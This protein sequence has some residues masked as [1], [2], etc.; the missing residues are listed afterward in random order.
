MN[1]ILNDEVSS[2]RAAVIEMIDKKVYRDVKAYKLRDNTSVLEYN[3]QSFGLA[4][5]PIRYAPES[6]HEG[7]MMALSLDFDNINVVATFS[8]EEKEKPFDA[9]EWNVELLRLYLQRHQRVIYRPEC[10][11]KNSDRFICHIPMR[12][13]KYKI[14]MKKTDKLKELLA[15]FMK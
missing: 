1:I 11:M 9:D 13:G 8:D 4:S 6:Y 5:E 3:D 10:M 12:H 2:T 15:E 14:N 7:A